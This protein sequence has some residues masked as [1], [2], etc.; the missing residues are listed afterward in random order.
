VCPIDGATAGE[1]TGA[2]VV[3]GLS[4]SF[5]F[6]SP[7]ATRRLISSVVVVVFVIRIL[8]FGGFA[9]RQL[10]LWVV[11]IS[12]I[13]HERVAEHLRDF[14]MRLLR[15]FIG[16]FVAVEA[17][18]FTE[19]D[20]DELVVGERAVDRSDETLIDAAFADLHDR[21]EVVRERAKVTSLLTGEHL[22]RVVPDEPSASGRPNCTSHA[23]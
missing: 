16:R 15:D 12:A 3:A 7:H 17:R 5:V 2:G 20:L 11:W 19:L 18:R 9:L 13:E 8:G 4:G 22:V 1:E 6:V 21:L 14:G 10:D 23:R